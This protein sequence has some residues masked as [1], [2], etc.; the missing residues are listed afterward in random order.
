[1][2][3]E[4]SGAAIPEHQ[5]ECARYDPPGGHKN[6]TLLGSRTHNPQHFKVRDA[7]EEHERN[8]SRFFVRD[9]RTNEKVFARP[10]QGSTG[11]YLRT[12]PDASAEDNL[13]HLREC[14]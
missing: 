7:V 6:I 5:I 1:M 4:A 8:E 11:K 3:D 10:V 2:P 13:D 9:P 12:A 14:P